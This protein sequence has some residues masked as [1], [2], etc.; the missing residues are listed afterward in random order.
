MSDSRFDGS[1]VAAAGERPVAAAPEDSVELLV[2]LSPDAEDSSAVT[3]PAPASAAAERLTISTAVP[4][5]FA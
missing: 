4:S 5:H 1:S 2:E 3:T